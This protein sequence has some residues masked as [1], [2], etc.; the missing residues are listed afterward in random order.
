VRELI[1]AGIDRA[2]LIDDLAAEDLLELL[3]D[4]WFLVCA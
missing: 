2:G 1:D 4:F 3:R